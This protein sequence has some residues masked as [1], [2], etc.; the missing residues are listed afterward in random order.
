MPYTPVGGDTAQFYY[1]DTGAPEGTTSYKTLV[2]IH[3]GVF[4]SGE[5]GCLTDYCVY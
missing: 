2:L 4:H 5:H 1:E 3:G